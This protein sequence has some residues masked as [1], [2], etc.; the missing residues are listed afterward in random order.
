MN[1]FYISC[2]ILSTVLGVSY[3]LSC[4]NTNG[5]QAMRNTNVVLMKNCTSPDDKSC[6][7]QAY[8]VVNWGDVYYNLGCSSQAAK[9][10]VKM[11]KG[12]SG[13]YWEYFCDYDY[14]NSSGTFSPGL[15]LI[16][17]AV[18]FTFWKQ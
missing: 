16:L 12:P 17:I 5:Y 13:K 10:E 6:F 3:G 8:K 11:D 18:I 2:V 1:N 15:G 4:W 7:S 9:A 14:C